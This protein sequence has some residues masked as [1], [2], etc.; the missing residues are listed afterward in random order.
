MRSPTLGVALLTRLFTTRS[1]CC[2]VT[3]ALPLLW[4]RWGS[5]GSGWLMVA[6]LG[7]VP[8]L[9]PRAAGVSVGVADAATVPPVQMPPAYVPWLGMAVIRVNPAGKA[10]AMLTL[11]AASG[12]LS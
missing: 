5:I 9:L 4:P 10:S 12:P 8:G 7:S 2:G 1:A 6:V 11:V 3:V